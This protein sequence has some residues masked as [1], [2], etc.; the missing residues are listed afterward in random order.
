MVRDF[1][2]KTVQELYETI[3]VNVDEEEQWKVFDFVEDFFME[4][5]EIGDYINDINSYHL[6]M[7][8]KHDVTTKKFDAIVEKAGKVDANYA[9]QIEGYC[10]LLGEYGK[11]F[12]AVCAMLQPEKL[13][14]SPDKY[15]EKLEGIN[16]G[17]Q[18]AKDT[19]EQEQSAYE[20][21]LYEIETVWY[22]KML[23]K[24]EDYLIRSAECIV[25]G[26]F[27]DE[28]TVLGVGVQIVLGIFDLDLPCDIRDI[29]ADIKN[30]AET[31]R[32]RW[33]LIGMLALDLIGLI[34][35][36]GALKY[37]D[38]IG[39][40]FKNADKVSVVARSTDGAGV[41][42]K[43]ADEAG[44]WLHGVK[45]FRYSDETAEAVA[46]GEKLLKESGTIYESFA[47]MMS[48]EDAKRY[49]DFLENGSR[50]G[51]TSAELAGVEK[52]DALLV[53]QKVG[54]ED[55]WDLRNAGDV[56]ESGSKGGLDTIIKNGK[57]SID[58]IKTNPSAFSG[59]TA[60]EIAD[61][62]RNSG[63]D[64]TIKN[65]T[66]SRSGAQ[67]IQINNSGGG[68]NISQVQVSP[69][70]GRHGS[71]PYVKI[72]TT[73]Q[74]I[75]KIVDGIEGTYKTDGKETATIIFSGGN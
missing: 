63:Y 62:L 58:D 11:K 60:E 52:A 32:V 21:E 69:G 38:E 65:S 15:R 6:H 41:L 42:A 7:F 50:E 33:D 67:I 17:Y 10:S 51:L 1:S 16:T 27:T 5:L 14:L 70:G 54:Y 29:I 36:I 26:N 24:A 28:V 37:S 20:A 40:L 57:V 45:V 61:V 9:A 12:E 2:Q 47:D 46:S 74:G 68:K 22:K 39:T 34:P 4:E 25:L 56:L 75:I 73:D 66:R 13:R 19:H 8:D 30:L 59:K 35:V 44:A 43:H 49:L 64:V 72:S 53:S 55:V 3:R 31:D 23:D 71:N 48:P 18:N